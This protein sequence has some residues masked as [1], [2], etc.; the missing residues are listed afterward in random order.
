[1]FVF[2]Y[3]FYLSNWIGWINIDDPA[4]CAGYMLVCIIYYIFVSLFSERD[5]VHKM[6]MAWF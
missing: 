2:D 6:N 1:M 5:L 4:L 3:I